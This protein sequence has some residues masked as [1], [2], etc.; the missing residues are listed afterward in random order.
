MSQLFIQQIIIL[1]IFGDIFGELFSFLAEIVGT[2]ASAIWDAISWIGSLIWDAITW[3]GELLRDLFQFLI[4]LLISFFEVIY[5]LIDGFLYFLY[6][7]GLLAVKVF[8]I[9][10]EVGKLIISFIQGIAATLQSLFFTPGGTGGHGYSGM[11]GQ[12]F[13]ALE[14]L[15]LHVI[16]YVLLFIIWISTAFAVIRIL[17]NLRGAGGS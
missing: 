4:D 11:I 3:L 1:G 8:M 15:Q 7:I 12:I 10:F 16:A 2:I 14:V 5:A 9:F 13:T 6:N 17:S